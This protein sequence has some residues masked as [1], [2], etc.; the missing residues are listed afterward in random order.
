MVVSDEMRQ[1]MREDMRGIPTR[2]GTNLADVLIALAERRGRDMDE[3]GIASRARPAPKAGMSDDETDDEDDDYSDKEFAPYVVLARAVEAL[4]EKVDTLATAQA[5]KRQ[6]GAE[7]MDMVSDILAQTTRMSEALTE[8][9]NYT[10][11]PSK[12]QE[13]QINPDDPHAEFLREKNQTGDDPGSLLQQI[14]GRSGLN[15]NG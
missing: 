6:T 1:R 8:L 7:T 5:E 2:D 12:A 15:G 9:M 14:R 3:R 4:S 13:T 10:P 11:R